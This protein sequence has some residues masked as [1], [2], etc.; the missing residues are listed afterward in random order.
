VLLF[1]VGISI[2]YS[3]KFTTNETSRRFFAGGLSLFDGGQ[4]EKHLNEAYPTA[5]HGLRAAAVSRAASTLSGAVMIGG[6]GY[7]SF[8]M[9]SPWSTSTS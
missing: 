2:Q 4:G 3:M 7:A 8:K 5:D 9:F 6:F 1:F